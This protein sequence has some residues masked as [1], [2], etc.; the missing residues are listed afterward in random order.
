M[1]RKERILN[2][3]SWFIFFT[4]TI[5]TLLIGQLYYLTTK[6][7]DYSF[8]RPYFEYFFGNISSTGVEQGLLYYFINATIISI[9]SENLI[10]VLWDQYFSNSIQWGNFFFYLIGIYGIYTFLKQKNTEKR[11]IFIILSLINL[12]PPAVEMRL[13]FKPEILVFSC[14]IWIIVFFD[15]YLETESLVYLLSSVPPLALVL[16]TKANLA[17][18]II[19]FLLS[20]YLKKIYEIN[21]VNFYKGLI[22]LTMFFLVTSFE[23]YQANELLIYEH[24][25]PEEFTNSAE[26]EFLYNI[27]LETLKN[28]PFRQSQK[29]SYL[30][31][32][33][34]DTFDDYFGNFWND[35]SSPLYLNRSVFFNAKE[36]AYLGIVFTLIFYAYLLSNIFKNK[37][38]R[39]LYTMPFFGIFFQMILSQFIQYDPSTGD[40]AKTYYYAFFLVIIFALLLSELSKQKVKVFLL[41]GLIF[42]VSIVHVYGFPK[43]QSD[44]AND[45]INM[46]NEISSLCFFGNMLLKNVDSDCEEKSYIVCDY[47]FNIIET[48]I[49][50]NSE[51]LYQDNFPVSE[52]YFSKNNKNFIVTS[53]ED[54]I[55]NVDSGNKV[56]QKYN[57]D[58]IPFINLLNLFLFLF[59]IIFYRYK[60]DS[61]SKSSYIY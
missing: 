36:T 3:F 30:G 17:I 13:L 44:G 19:L 60:N 42:S 15:K 34:L 29:D 41:V 31:V 12:F 61:S 58:K 14:L 56:I 40:V 25:S 52:I 38:Y 47:A 9:D 8:Y 28:D 50:S 45:F 22:I 27:N 59:S 53:F 48:V 49:I 6:G 21:A 11:N 26:L 33:I 54:C 46:N 2:Y 18:M 32:M 39:Y 51:Y 7:P 55:A 16:T 4:T 35:D 43:N 37:N 23:N 5:Y 57:I 10:P 20:F 1:T 24:Q